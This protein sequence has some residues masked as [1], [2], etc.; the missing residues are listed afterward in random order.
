MARLAI[1][2]LELPNSRSGPP[3]RQSNAHTPFYPPSSITC[4]L[5]ILPLPNPII[6]VQ[7]CLPL[8]LFTL[9][10]SSSFWRTHV[11]DLYWALILLDPRCRFS[12]VFPPQLVQLLFPPP[13]H[14]GQKQ[15]EQ[16]AK[17]DLDQSKVAG[18]R[19]KSKPTGETL[20]LVPP[21]IALT[22][23]F[24]LSLCLSCSQHQTTH[25]HTHELASIAK[26]Y[27][28]PPP[29]PRSSLPACASSRTSASSPRFSL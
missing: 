13:E 6:L 25:I 26:W 21:P 5:W 29:P 22:S 24:F 4:P 11:C 12:I 27:C 8:L 18:T 23:F 17:A 7:I 19:R 28:S 15:Q 9:T 16:K 14:P 10:P 1:G 2:G 20:I 3:H